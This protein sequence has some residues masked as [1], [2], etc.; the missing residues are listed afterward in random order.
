MTELWMRFRTAYGAP[1]QRLLEVLA[2]GA[3]IEHVAAALET[4]LDE[5]GPWLK[6]LEEEGLVRVGR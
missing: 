5:L 3:T 2:D 4:D 6:K 1:G